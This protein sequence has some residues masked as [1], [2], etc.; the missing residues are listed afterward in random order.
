MHRND[1]PEALVHAVMT[2]TDMWERDL[3][4]IEGFEA[5]T[6][7]NLRLIREKGAIAAFETCL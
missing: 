1:T 3:T 7:E 5:L 4:K 2:N 6:V